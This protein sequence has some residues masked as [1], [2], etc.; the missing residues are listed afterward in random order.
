MRS[1][2]VNKS[3]LAGSISAR[4]G[5]AK[6]DV[7]IVITEVFSQVKTEVRLGSIVRINNFGLFKSVMRKGKVGNDISRNKQVIIPAHKVPVFR[8]SQNFKS[9]I[10]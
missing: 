9:K 6:K 4:T 10:K 1:S 2:I 5:I 8:A 3:Q 7:E